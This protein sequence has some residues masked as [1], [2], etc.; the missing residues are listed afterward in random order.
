MASPTGVEMLGL[1]AGDDDVGAEAGELGG[2]G[3]AQPGAGAGDEDAAPSKV[4]AG[5][6]PAPRSRR[7]GQADQ[8]GHGSA[9]GVVGRP[10]LEAGR[11]ELGEILDCMRKVW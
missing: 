8:F 2:D 10:A 7:F 11:L 5:R 6:A 3:L 1:A 9:P 4:P